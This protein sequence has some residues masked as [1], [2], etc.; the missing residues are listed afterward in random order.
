MSKEHSL[1]WKMLDRQDGLHHP[2]SSTEMTPLLPSG[3]GNFYTAGESP[4]LLAAA[5]YGVV[6]KTN[7]A[8]AALKM[9]S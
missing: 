5:L 8:E 2:F 1:S 3:Q 4:K 7:D 9:G 6:D